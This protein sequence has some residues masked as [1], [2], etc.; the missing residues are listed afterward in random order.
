MN[1][2][3]DT[4]QNA[5]EAELALVQ[6]FL[7][8]LQAE[9]A[10]LEQP[11]QGEALNASTQEKNACIAQLM[12]AGQARENA[13]GELGYSVDKAGLETAAAAYP[14]LKETSQMLFKLGQQAS[15]LNSANGAIIST[16]LRHTQ[17]ALQAMRHLVG[18][19][20]LYDA[21]GRPDA[22]KGQRKTIAAG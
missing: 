20:G 4:L 21:S 22:V 7:D 15:D 18:E 5:L 19:P 12:Q 14:H 9:A 6:R 10:A 1:T 13:L 3:P 2:S 11:D 8:I 16:Y 17:Q